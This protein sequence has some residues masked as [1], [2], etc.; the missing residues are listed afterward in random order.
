MLFGEKI[1]PPGKFHSGGFSPVMLIY[2][3][4][5]ALLKQI[6]LG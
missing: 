2:V 4:L 6:L 5:P 3:A 1:I